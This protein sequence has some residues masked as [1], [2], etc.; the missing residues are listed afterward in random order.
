MNCSK[1]GTKLHSSSIYAN[2]KKLSSGSFCPVCFHQVT[3]SDELVKYR[4][5]I[6]KEQQDAPKPK[7]VKKQRKACPYCYEKGIVNRSKWTIRKMPK[8][9]SEN[10]HWKCTCQRC[11]NVWQQNT[12]KQYFYY[13]PNEPKF[14]LGL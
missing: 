5:K 14:T 10:Q 1:C 12:S 3:F 2:R 7:F 11:G 6:L 8:K 4:N 9:P 13:D